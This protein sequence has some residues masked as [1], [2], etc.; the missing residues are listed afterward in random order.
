MASPGQKL[1]LG[2]RHTLTLAHI[3]ADNLIYPPEER[4][5]GTD[6]NDG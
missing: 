4:N 1:N 5:H 2:V 3:G 6:H